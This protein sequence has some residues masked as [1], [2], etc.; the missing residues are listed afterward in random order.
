MADSFPPPDSDSAAG[1]LLLE[2]DL[3]IFAIQDQWEWL[4]PWT[5]SEEQPLPLDLSGLGDIDLSGFQLLAA[6]AQTLH[7]KGHRLVLTGL[8]EEW[9][10]RLTLLGLAD[11]LEGASS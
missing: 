2:G 4:A 1:P 6:A 9:R 7:T 5:A 11:L 10:S 3:D 8:K